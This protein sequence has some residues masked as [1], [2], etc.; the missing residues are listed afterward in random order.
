MEILVLFDSKGGNV[1]AL[2]KAIAEGIEHVEGIKARMRWVKETTPLEVIR[3]DDN[4]SKFY[5]F[6]TSEIPQANLNDLVETE[7]LAMGC[8]TRFGN[9]SPAMGN[10]LE[11]T[12]QLWAKGSL[13]G[14]VAGVFTSTSTMHGGNEATLISMMIPLMHL[15]YIIVPMGYTDPNVAST[16]RGGTPYGPSSVS[17]LGEPT[18]SEKELS[19][20]R[21]FGKR[22]AEITK[23]LR[24]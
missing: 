13:V 5:D 3:A 14:K 4:W 19:I 20:A 10:F 24:S 7:G 6:K 11:S 17:A 18:P 1:Y 23:K 22:L 12:G 15:G 8:P 2:A 16:D 21:T 9:I